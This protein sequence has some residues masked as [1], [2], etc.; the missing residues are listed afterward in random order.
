MYCNSIRWHIPSKPYLSDLEARGAAYSGQL[1]PLSPCN[2]GAKRGHRLR[3]IDTTSAY[4]M[5]VADFE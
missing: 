2:G 1:Q 3:D 4:G 5:A